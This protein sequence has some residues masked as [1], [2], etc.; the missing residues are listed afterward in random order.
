MKLKKKLTNKEY[1]WQR[2]TKLETQ[3]YII[4]YL[5]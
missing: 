3:S 4:Y 2:L 1:N 5:S